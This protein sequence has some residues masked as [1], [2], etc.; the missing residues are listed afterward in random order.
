MRKNP[1]KK[2][3]TFRH[4]PAPFKPTLPTQTRI[5]ELLQDNIELSRFQIAGALQLPEEEISFHLE[6]L[7]KHRMLQVRLFEQDTGEK[8]KYYRIYPIRVV[9]GKSAAKLLLDPT[10][11]QIPYLSSV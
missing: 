7:K 11:S 9:T 2:K 3:S 5:I 8:E 6:T 4:T 1:R 10:T